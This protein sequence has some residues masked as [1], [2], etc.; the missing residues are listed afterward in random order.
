M[1]ST[2]ELPRQLARC[3]GAVRD[4]RAWEEYASYSGVKST[5]PAGVRPLGVHH[6]N[7][8]WARAAAALLAWGLS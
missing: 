2:N 1:R 4:A 8:A 5:R 7:D 3:L 6:A